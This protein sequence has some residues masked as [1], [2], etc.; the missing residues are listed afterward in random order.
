MLRWCVALILTVLAL[1]ARA[2]EALPSPL[3]LKAALEV[4]DR[5]PVEVMAVAQREVALSAERFEAQQ[6]NRLRLALQGKVGV[7][8]YAP[9]QHYYHRLALVASKVLYDGGREQAL[10]KA[11][12]RE[13]AALSLQR[14]QAM[15]RYRLKVA[16]AFFDVLLADVRYR[17]LNEEM[18]VAY[19]ELDRLRDR[20]ELGTV[21]DVD[22][23]AK[24]SEYARLLLARNEAELAQR[25]RRVELAILLG[26]PDAV[27]DE[28]APPPLKALS[29]IKVE[30][31]SSL[32]ARLADASP[33][34]LALRQQLQAVEARM[35]WARL[36]R[37]PTLSA[38]ASAGPRYFEKEVD[39]GAWDV[40]LQLSWPLIDGG[41][42]DAA[43]AGVE[44][45]RLR[46]LMEHKRLSQTLQRRVVKLW[47]ELAVLKSR[48]A[49]LKAYQDFVDLNME[50]KR[51]LYENE[52]R[53]DIGDAM[54]E[55]SRY[56]EAALESAFRALLAWYEL[57]LIMGERWP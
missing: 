39:K 15:A 13:Q 18:A 38:H 36:Q 32:L 21:S 2:Q 19:V 12:G 29:E 6:Q 40:H 43:R 50:Y 56:D 23:A 37:S 30:E 46:L 44:A 24:E 57:K 3:T 9:D 49:W 14:S 25:Q 4:A 34:L 20:H 11:L 52:E 8:Q 22:L 47:G 1:A 7:Y 45:Q 28:V 26:R 41:V 5:L 48:Q 35:Q 31:L 55:Q 53:T 33:D 10:L 17:R 42:S 51:G 54:I 16:E 27:I